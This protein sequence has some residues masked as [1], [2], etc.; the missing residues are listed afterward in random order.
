MARQSKILIDTNTYL[1]LAQSVRP[2]LHQEF[3]EHNY[4]LYVIPELNDELSVRRLANK[5]P[6]VIEDE[7][8]E[9][10]QYFPTLSKKQRKS[11]DVTYSYLWSYVQTD[12]PGP[13]RVDA[14]YVSYGLELDLPIVTDDS[15]MTDLAKAFDTRVMRTMVL[16]KMMLDAGHVDLKKIDAMVAYWR[17]IKDTPGKMNKDYK[18]LFKK[19]LP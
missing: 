2:L 11:I 12:C 17:H 3:G 7:Y 19:P 6:W 14:R 5:F 18:R 4:C 10:R 1:R 13:S 16:L 15:D 8:S 9:N